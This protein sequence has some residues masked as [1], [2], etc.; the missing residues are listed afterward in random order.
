[1]TWFHDLRIRAKLLLGFGSVL[2]LL[3]I[4]GVV[5]SFGMRKLRIA[6]EELYDRMTVPL[7]QSG[8]AINYLQR[9]RVNLREAVYAESPRAAAPFLEKVAAYPILVDSLLKE[10]EK[11]ITTDAGRQAFAAFAADLRT[12]RGKRDQLVK[13][14][15]AGNTAAAIAYLG[16]DVRETEEKLLVSMKA[17]QDQKIARAAEVKAGNEVLSKR[18]SWI[19]DLSVAFGIALGLAIA[20]YIA[21]NI[22]KVLALMVERANRLQSVC[23]SNLGQAL[24]ALAAGKLDVK[25]EYGT[26]PLNITSKDELGELARSVDGIIATSVDSIRSYE[27]AA[28]TMQGLIAETNQLVAAAQAGQ[29]SRRA[30]G[31]KYQG[32]YRQLVDGVNGMLDAI[33]AP[34]AESSAVLGRIAE[35][36]LTAQMTGHYSGDFDRIRSAVNLAVTNLQRALGDVSA[37][38]TQVSSASEEISAAAQ[39]L[40]EGASEQ[41]SSLEEVAAS[42]HEVSAT[43]KNSAE[44]AQSARSVTEEARQQAAEGLQEMKQLEAAVNR[45]KSSAHESAKIIKTIDEI[46]FQTNLLALNAAVEAA[47]AGD[48]GRG[49]AVV[50]EEVRN[51]AMR[52]AEAARNTTDLIA[53]SVRNADDGVALN[54]R[55]LKQFSTIA[56]HVESAGEAMSE[57]AAGSDQQALGIDQISTAVEQINIVTQRAAANAEESSATSIELAGQSTHLQELVGQF[58]LDANA[59]YETRAADPGA[60][61]LDMPGRRPMGRRQL[62]GV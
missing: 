6:D 30:A 18:M 60:G 29:L 20:L 47:R 35:R 53:E 7:A 1:M 37:S 14:I 26:S 24:D 22:G 52:A 38:A 27:K 45:I 41:A 12:F 28:D 55:A 59:R 21:A 58:K 57:I 49:F 42:L 43:A 62:A 56:Q 61:A 54:A 51:L 16:S 19:I 17:M 31:E 46:A 11:S 4:V 44:R 9:V 10:Y 48:A 13:L 32:G 50:A 25:P 2:T 5:A 39:S 33:T 36:D 34:I 23:I 40:A 15:N 3:L 8:D